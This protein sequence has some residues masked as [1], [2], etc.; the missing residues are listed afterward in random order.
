MSQRAL[1]KIVS[2]VNRHWILRYEVLGPATTTAG[3]AVAIISIVRM[4]ASV[5]VSLGHRHPLDE[6]SRPRIL[7]V[8]LDTAFQVGNGVLTARRRSSV[9]P[10]GGE[11]RRGGPSTV[12]EEG[13]RLLH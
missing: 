1:E 5:V 9:S 10:H 3:L 12:E 8:L 11:S 13:S 7:G 6:R 2:A 4:M